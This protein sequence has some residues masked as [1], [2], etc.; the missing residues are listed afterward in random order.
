MERRG[1]E[2]M[3]H[4]IVDHI[5]SL[6]KA[7]YSIST[8]VIMN[9]DLTLNILPKIIWIISINGACVFNNDTCFPNLRICPT[10]LFPIDLCIILA[11]S[12]K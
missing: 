3:I 4:L 10:Q 9:I 2:I 8:L 12:I 7:I 6:E 1:E 11:I 5:I